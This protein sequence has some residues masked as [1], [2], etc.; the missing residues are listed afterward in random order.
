MKRK[1]NDGMSERQAERVI[2]T[3]ENAVKN[4]EEWAHRVFLHRGTEKYQKTLD[5]LNEA[6][7]IKE[8]DRVISPLK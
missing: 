5:T 2:E 8:I 6:F 3:Y 4:G 1:V 7:K